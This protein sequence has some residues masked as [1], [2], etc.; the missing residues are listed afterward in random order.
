MNIRGVFTF[1][2]AVAC[3]LASTQGATPPEQAT[4]KPN[5]IVIFTDDQGWA[6][7]SCQGSV[8]DVRTP[9]IDRLAR[10]GVRMT[11][12]Y[13]TAPQCVPSRAG[14]LTGRYQQR[15]GVDHNGRGPLPRDVKTLPERLRQAGYVTGMVG[16]W[17]LEPNRTC[18]EWVA[19][20]LPRVATKPRG[21]LRI[22]PAK[23]APYLPGR[24]GFSEFFLGQFSDYRANFDLQG[25]SLRPEG[26]PVRTG[27][28]RLDAQ[29]NAAV[30]FIRRNKDR[31]FFLYLAYFAPH[32]PLE[33]TQK[34]LSRFPGKMAERRRYGLAMI[35][36]M[37]D[38]VGNILD[39]LQTH[40]IDRRT[41]VFFI[42]DNGAPLKIHKTDLPITM[43]GGAWDGSL[44]D[45]WIG[46]KGMITEGGI[47]VPFIMRWKGVLPEGRVYEHPVISLDVAATALALAGRPSPSD[48][49]GA[50]LIP[51]LTGAKT[52]PP[53]QALYW[54]FWG[55]AA[56]R[57]G[58]W[59]YLYLAGGTQ[60]LFDLASPQHERRNVIGDHRA[61]AE[62]LRG[63]LSRW[64]EGLHRPGL[65]RGKLNGQETKWYQHYL[66]LEPR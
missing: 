53:H 27:Q 44:N 22:P 55:Q 39:E 24:R 30:A 17:H 32:V 6:D 12:G 56:V 45:P 40:G 2:L 26:E 16:K 14:I 47:R 1:V 5:V 58:S 49:D 35:S 51:Y 60:Y 7:V 18:T 48:L 57:A 23:I 65:P 37:D 46:E 41:L 11:S 64:T 52:G 63:Q 21:K 10:E 19:E 59:K 31:P 43:R 50:D 9:H 42:S 20:N 66:G 29:S 3:L 15:F 34:Y 36:A 61:L 38:G 13:V 62:R 8:N 4:P 33:A 25:A 28:Y 54:R